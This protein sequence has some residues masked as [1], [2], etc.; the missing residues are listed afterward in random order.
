MAKNNR[1]LGKGLGALFGDTENSYENANH[2]T[3]SKE[4][5]DN[6]EVSSVANE[7]PIGEIYA[8]PNQPRK[9]FD[10]EALNELAASIKIHGVIQPIVV[11]KAKDGRY[12]II[13][14]ERRF[15]ACNIAGLEN[16]PVVI[17]NYSAKEVKEVSIIEN[18]QREDLNP[19]EAGRAI[20][21]LME[22]YDYTQEEVSERLGKS[23]PAIANTL[24]LLTLNPFVIDKVECGELSAGHARNLVVVEDQIVQ[25]HLAKTAIDRHM[26]VRDFEKFVKDALAGNLN[27]KPVSK[28]KPPLSLE[29]EDLHDRFQKV[30]ATKVHV[31]GNEN[32]GRISI[33]YFTSDDLERVHEM[34]LILEKS[35]KNND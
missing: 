19:I 21:E 1:G 34:L 4:K 22:V 5:N 11:N 14:G 30:F 31:V 12:M 9:K 13:A 27:K 2:S 32:K 26:S 33:D 24:R 35:K 20:K 7:L 16:V 10:D 25:I 3:P 17:K 15:R 8:N 6:V 18:L 28:E 23:R 29:L